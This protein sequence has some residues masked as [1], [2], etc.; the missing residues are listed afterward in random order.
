MEGL[1]VSIINLSQLV[2][3]NPTYRLDSEFFKKEYINLFR[4]ILSKR[5]NKLVNLSDWITQGP[6]PSFSESHI[7]CLT[8]RN[9]NKSR[10]N[11]NNADYISES[12]YKKLERFQ[13]N[14]GDTL[15][16]LKGKGSIG[17]IGFVTEDRKAIFSRDIGL[18]RP[19]SIDAAYVNAYLLS[20]F[21]AKTIERGETGGTGQSTLTSSYLK[22]VDVVRLGIESNIGN[23]I[24]Q[25]EILI[26]KSKNLYTQA[27]ELLLEEVGLKDFQ[28]TQKA[29]NIKSFSES[30]GSSGRLDAEYYQPKYD[31]IESK[32]L[33]NPH[34]ILG[35]IITRIETGEYSQE[36]FHK[37]E[38]NNLSFYIRSTNINHGQIEIDNRYFVPKFKFKKIAKTGDIVTARVG[39][40][41]IFGEIREH[42]SGSIYSDNVINFRLPEDF[43]PSV[44]TLLFNTKYYFDIIEK[45]SRGSVQQRLNQETMKDL[46][47][48]IIDYN[49]QQQIAQLIEQSFSLQQQSK[50]LL[51]IA[52]RAV[53]LAIEEE[54][55]IALK[56]I[57]EQTKDL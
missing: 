49:K 32:L 31:A 46:I 25:S 35:N 36:Y 57:E 9:I 19:N 38:Q 55:D 20:Y 2:F 17:K 6:N 7:P 28:P 22:N 3:N 14:I 45:L 16:T 12:E 53:E 40:V 11:Y 47:I 18:I 21:G 48:P 15:I 39:S 27:E 4:K 41:G 43:T 8:G 10:V 42:T 23:L 37:N 33:S 13:L 56:Y 34:I 50:Q 24:R 1:E 44:Y 5:T 29:V 26:L 52:K 51:E 30:F 54:E